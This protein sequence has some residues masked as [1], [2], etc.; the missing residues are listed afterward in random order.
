MYSHTAH[1]QHRSLSLSR[2]R[3]IQPDAIDLVAGTRELRHAIQL[4]A[5]TLDMPN[6]GLTHLWWDACRWQGTSSKILALLLCNN[7]NSTA[8]QS[9]SALARRTSIT[10]N[11]LDFPRES[12]T[13]VFVQPFDL[14]TARIY[15]SKRVA[16]TRRR[17]RVC[18]A[19]PIATKLQVRGVRLQDTRPTNEGALA[20][21]KTPS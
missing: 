14:R 10:R 1:A 8:F 19:M 3:H 21:S 11:N 17:A 4:W 6:R 16:S 18:T 9:R 15:L 20:R 13:R 5:Q 12:N 2:P 7:V